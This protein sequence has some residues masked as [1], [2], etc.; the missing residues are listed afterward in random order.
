MI[1]NGEEGELGNQDLHMPG[2][3]PKIP[4][5]LYVHFGKPIET[6]GKQKELNNKEKAHDVYLQV[7]SEVERCMS[8]LKMQRESDPYRNIFTRLLYSVSHGFSSQI[9]TFDLYQAFE[10]DGEEDESETSQRGKVCYEMLIF[11]VN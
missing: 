8:Y 2:I 4:G 10:S 5:R 6:E 11:L 7:K 9:P 1:R 3:V